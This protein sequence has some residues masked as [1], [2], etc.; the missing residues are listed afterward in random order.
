AAALSAR[1]GLS[2]M[3]LLSRCSRLVMP[4]NEK[5]PGAGRTGRTRR[6]TPTRTVASLRGPPAMR[7]TFDRDPVNRRPDDQRSVGGTP[8]A[9]V[10]QAS[11]LHQLAPRPGAGPG[12]RPA[13]PAE[14]DGRRPPIGGR[15]P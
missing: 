7:G 9:S 4:V 3:S 12:G 11:P 6:Y 10:R 13:N 8:S 15:R 14:D 5:R 1:T 2:A